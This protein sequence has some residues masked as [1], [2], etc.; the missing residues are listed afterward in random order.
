M[1]KKRKNRHPRMLPTHRTPF[2]ITVNVNINI[3][4]AKSNGILKKLFSFCIAGFS[5]IHNFW[6]IIIAFT[7]MF[8]LILLICI[9]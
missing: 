4:V 2:N 1:A 5:H 7:I 6:R 8:L 9:P 3:L